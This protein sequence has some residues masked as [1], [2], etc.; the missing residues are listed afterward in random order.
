MNRALAIVISGPS[1]CGK[2]TIVKRLVRQNDSV[3][4]SVSVTTRGIR[5]DDGEENGREY[6][7]ISREKYAELLAGGELLEHAEYSSGSYGTPKKPVEQWLSAN[8]DVILEI[9]VQGFR[10]VREKLPDAVS[11][12]VAPPDMGVLRERLCMRATESEEEIGRRI[13]IGKKELEAAREYDYIVVNDRLDSAVELIQSIIL[14]EKAKS[15]YMNDF[16][17]GVLND[18]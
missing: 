18:D 16:I 15:R 14:S 13:A 8:N 9:D 1:G 2:G 7:F 5:H 3:K 6:H 11:I 10:Q 17:K 12:F 4:L